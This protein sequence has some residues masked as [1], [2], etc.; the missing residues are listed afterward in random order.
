MPELIHCDE[1]LAVSDG[2]LSPEAF[3]ALHRE[4]A[5][6]DYR[7]VH[8]RGWDK[9]WRLWDGRPQRG[10]SV[11][12]DPKRLF[13]WKGPTY[14]TA[15]CVDKLVDAVRGLAS[16]HPGI[17]GLEGVDWVALYL[18][19]WIY[20]VGSALSLHRDGQRYSGSFT[21]FVHRRWHVNWGGE[22]IVAANGSFSEQNDD[23]VLSED[24]LDATADRGVSLCIHPKP[25]RLVLLGPERPHRVA[26]V[27]TNAGAHARVSVAGFF[28][29][30]PAP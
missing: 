18:S 5:R 24:A 1:A 3:N 7:E 10:D 21:F 8:S 6:G 4:V 11:Y 27:D 25:N 12:F 16:E 19:P 2:V 9:A 14:P 29:C 28:L 20:P 13:G 30:A 22:L 15:T 17:V 23:T 26:R